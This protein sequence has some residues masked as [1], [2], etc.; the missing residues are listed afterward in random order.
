MV[1]VLTSCLVGCGPGKPR[2]DALAAAAERSVLLEVLVNVRAEEYSIRRWRT[3]D[4]TVRGNVRDAS[5]DD[6]S[7]AVKDLRLVVPKGFQERV[8]ARPG[9]MIGELT[10]R[11]S[12][13]GDRDGTRCV[14]ATW[15]FNSP[16]P[17]EG[18]TGLTI[19]AECGANLAV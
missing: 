6:C 12:Y 11:N 4:A 14:V 1:A 2:A 17:S 15:R 9:C 5:G 19:T 8:V 16:K 7:G 10:L 3:S 18:K 13:V